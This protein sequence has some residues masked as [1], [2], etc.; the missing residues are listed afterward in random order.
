MS[1]NATKLDIKPI[2]VLEQ[3]QEMEMVLHD[4]E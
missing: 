3:L 4:G 2:V 1:A